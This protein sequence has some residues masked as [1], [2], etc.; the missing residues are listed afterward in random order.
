MDIT[1]TIA[2]PSF[3]QLYNCDNN[4]LDDFEEKVG[5]SDPRHDSWPYTMSARGHRSFFVPCHKVSSPMNEISF[6]VKLQIL[7]DMFSFPS[8]QFFPYFLFCFTG[9]RLLIISCSFDT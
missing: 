5:K 3:V 6:F 8:P 7:L 2:E 4:L 9:S 1:P